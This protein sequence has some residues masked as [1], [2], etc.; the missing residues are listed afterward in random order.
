[1][2]KNSLECHKNGCGTP[3]NIQ[4]KTSI[5]RILFR[6]KHLYDETT[7]A[8]SNATQYWANIGTQSDH[9]LASLAHIPGMFAALWTPETAPKTAITL[10]TAGYGFAALPKNMIHFT[11]TAGARGIM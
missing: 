3:I 6:L 7:L 4:D 10:G 8:G 11:T 2:Q 9:P 1:M 5:D